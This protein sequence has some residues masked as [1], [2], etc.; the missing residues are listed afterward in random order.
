MS[1]NLTNASLVEWASSWVPDDPPG[2]RARFCEGLRAELEARRLQAFRDGYDWGYEHGGDG[3][4]DMQHQA[5]NAYTAPEQSSV[6]KP[7]DST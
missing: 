6:A 1:S 5:W 7:G 2:Q 3:K 4:S